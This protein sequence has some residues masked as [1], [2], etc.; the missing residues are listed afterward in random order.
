MENWPVN[1][2]TIVSDTARM[3]LTPI[4]STSFAEYASAFHEHLQERGD[5]DAR[6]ERAEPAQQR[7]RH[8]GSKAPCTFVELEDACGHR[9]G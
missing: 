3:M 1:P 6:D 8:P 4:S 7:R 2:F 5:H 9:G